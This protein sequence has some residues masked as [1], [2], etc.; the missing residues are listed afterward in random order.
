[1]HIGHGIVEVGG[2]AVAGLVG[3]FHL[4]ITGCGVSDSRQNALIHQILTHFDGSRQFRCH[5]PSRHAMEIFHNVVIF[6]GIRV[7]NDI[8]HLGTRL[9]DIE[10]RPF[11]VKPHDR[12]IGLAHQ[13]FAGVAGSLH[14]R[15]SGR[16]KRGIHGSGAMLEV[17]LRGS[18]KSIFRT[19]L[20]VASTAAMA[21]HFNATGH[22]VHPFG[23]NCQIG[24]GVY[25][26][27]I[28][29]F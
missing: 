5:I 12:A 16:R 25:I 14:H 24:I 18:K 17:R 8:R 13:F 20:K 2:V 26:A 23:I 27:M 1:M 15:E 4:R 22:H 21:V 11:E 10:V 6:I 19:L 7:A 3:G 9:F 29:N 28:A